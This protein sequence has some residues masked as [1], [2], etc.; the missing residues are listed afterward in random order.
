M[1]MQN[2]EMMIIFSINW[3]LV[4]IDRCLRHELARILITEDV[5]VSNIMGLFLYSFEMLQKPKRNSGE[6][7]K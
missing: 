1:Y 6:S 5:H 7:R 3:I 4:K 2:R